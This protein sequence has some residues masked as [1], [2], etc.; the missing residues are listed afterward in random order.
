MARRHNDVLMYPRDSD[1]PLEL[2]RLF[3]EVTGARKSA[4]E[5]VFEEFPMFRD[6]ENATPAMLVELGLTERQAQVAVATFRLVRMVDAY[7]TRAVD[8]ASI[9]NPDDVV[10]WVSRH[11]AGLDREHGVLILMNARSKVI[12]GIVIGSGGQA[13]TEMP[14][15]NIL[16]A[17]LRYGA[18]SM[19][20]VHNHPSGEVKPSSA[21]DLVT[22][23]IQEAG[24]RIG[25]PLLDH[26]IIGA[27]KT[28][29]APRFYSYAQMGRI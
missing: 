1:V 22:R 28:D 2:V 4:A 13:S 11:M 23:E 16:R 19:I 5:A 14:V 25:V 24:K 9:T 12:E 21:D 27:P 26:L 29:G 8:A 20:L 18:H 15:Q 6:L 3:R 7:R 10:Y 17:A